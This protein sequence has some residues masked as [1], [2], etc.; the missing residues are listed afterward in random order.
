MRSL[1]RKF[2]D[3]RRTKI[4]KLEARTI[5]SKTAKTAA[6]KESTPRVKVDR[7]R[8]I[9]VTAPQIIE[10]EPTQPTTLEITHQ[11]HIRRLSKTGAKLNPNTNDFV[12]KT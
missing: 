9:P 2:T 12:I 3:D 1:K 6:D 10:A 7:T 8:I 5:E 4:T 11:G